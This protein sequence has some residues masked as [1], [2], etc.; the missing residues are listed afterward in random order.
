MVLENPL[1]VNGQEYQ[2]FVVPGCKRITKGAADGLARLKRLGLPVYFVEQRPGRLCDSMDPT[3]S[4]TGAANTKKEGTIDLWALPEELKDCP[5]VTLAELPAC[6]RE[7]GIAAPVLNPACNRIR[8]LHIQGDTSCYMLVN[9]AAEPYQGTIRLPEAMERCFIYDAWENRCEA[10]SVTKNEEGTVLNITI[11]PLKSRFLIA[12][13]C[14]EPFYET[15]IPASE[16]PLTQWTRSICE[17]SA[18]PDFAQEKEVAL[19]DSLAEEQPEFSGFVRYETGFTLDKDE[20]LYLEIEDAKEGVE[21]FL[22]G[23]SAGMQI[24]PPY[25]YDLTGTAGE[26]VLVIEVATTLERQCY[27]LLE[28]YRKMLAKPPV[29]GS[30]LTG[31]VRLWLT[32][33]ETE[34]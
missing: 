5:V 32:K 25:R 16:I 22:N 8:I 28:G 15:A 23:Q 21:V 30:G 34:K 2:A 6:I 31:N 27:P 10:A 19:P 24:A 12:G 3:L 14:S 13:S 1:T 11:E 26:N 4:A 29:S 18:Y 20:K 33:E 17:G 7:L 9:E